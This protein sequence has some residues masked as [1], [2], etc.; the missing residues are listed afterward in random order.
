M[1]YAANYLEFT[2]DVSITHQMLYDKGWHRDGECQDQKH[3]KLAAFGD[4]SRQQ[5]IELVAEL[6]REAHPE[7]SLLI[8]KCQERL[9]RDLVEAIGVWG[10]THV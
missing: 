6:H 9:C 10:N 2:T 1:G 5:A 7:G 3:P 8:I 4:R